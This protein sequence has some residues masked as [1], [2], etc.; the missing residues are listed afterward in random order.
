M[1]DRFSSDAVLSTH[2]HG[3]WS[4]RFIRIVAALYRLVDLPP[5]VDRILTRLTKLSEV[6]DAHAVVSRFGPGPRGPIG[7]ERTPPRADAPIEANPAEVGDVS[8][9]E[10]DYPGVVRPAGARAPTEA[11]WP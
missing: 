9:F 10:S 3:S 1:P 4:D 6:P 7:S 11:N 2:I 5:S 8:E